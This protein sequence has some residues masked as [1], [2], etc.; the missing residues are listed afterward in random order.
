MKEVDCVS[1][2]GNATVTVTS[3]TSDLVT[4]YKI[5]PW[6]LRLARLRHLGVQLLTREQSQIRLK[7]AAGFAPGF[8]R[9]PVRLSATE[10]HRNVTGHRSIRGNAVLK[11]MWTHR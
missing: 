7:H 11:T 4:G 10:S 3:S 8:P 2:W 1:T 5:L 9:L 6:S